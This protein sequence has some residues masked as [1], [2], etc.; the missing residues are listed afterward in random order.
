MQWFRSYLTA[1]YQVVTIGT[2]SSER[3]H[4]ASGVPQGSILGPLLFSIYM[5]DLPSVPQHCSVQC[6]VDDT[7][8]LLSFRLHDQSRIVAEINQDLT[9]IRNWSFDNQL[10]LN[11]D[12]TKLLVC[13]SKHGAAKTRNFKLSFLGKQLAPVEAA[14]DLG[15][16]L[17][18]SLTFDDHVT[19]TVASCMSRLGQIN[20][21]KH[22]FDKRTLII[23]INALVFSKL[24]YCSSVWSNTSQSNIAKLQAVQNF[25]C[26]IVSGS[27]KYDHVTPIPKQL[28]WLPVKQ[29]MY[30]RDS[31]MA[32]KCMNGL[33]PGYL[34]DQLIKRSSISTR[35]TRNSQLLNIPLF[36][37]ATGQRSFY[38]RMVSLW[39]AL[40]QVIKL[41]Q[42]LA[43]FK[44]LIRKRLLM[45]S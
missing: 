35:K 12:K 44:T 14:R 2:A 20:R 24:F 18:T 40:P 13:G 38:Y 17:D 43:Q 25:A 1:R 8:L 16:I 28:N 10:L 3:L 15:V 31:I 21:V 22:C 27:K 45:D 32:F 34:S 29:H 6:Y 7:K 11:P 9:R 37:T 23:I 5:N 33:V 30:Y 36:K 4:V 19:A 39:N 42:S 41:S 26:R